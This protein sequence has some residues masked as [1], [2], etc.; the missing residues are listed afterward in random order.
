M[1]KCM[2]RLC[3]YIMTGELQLS[4]VFR[5]TFIYFNNALSIIL[6]LL[7]I[8]Y[9]QYITELQFVQGNQKCMII[10]QVASSVRYLWW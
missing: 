3:M 8:A 6:I 1:Q 2:I 4:I 9:P 5:I 7:T 10:T